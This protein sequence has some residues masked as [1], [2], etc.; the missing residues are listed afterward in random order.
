MYAKCS[1]QDLCIIAYEDV[2]AESDLIWATAT[3]VTCLESAIVA[4]NWPSR[5]GR[6]SDTHC[7]ATLDTLRPDAA[8]LDQ[9]LLSNIWPTLRT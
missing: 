4:R 7:T 1:V 2:D 6:H 9:R 5:P 8:A 3:C